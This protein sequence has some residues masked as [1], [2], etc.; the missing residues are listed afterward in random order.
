[1]LTTA[2]RITGTRLVWIRAI[3]VLRAVTKL[4][5]I[6]QNL[7]WDSMLVV[8]L[9]VMSDVQLSLGQHCQFA[10]E[11]VRL[12]APGSLLTSG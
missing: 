2:P 11:P 7:L 1:M 6:V 8:W 3:R 10:Q 9:S 4:F 5:L 12:S